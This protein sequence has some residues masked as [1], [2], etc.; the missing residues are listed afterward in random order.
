[1]Y[2]HST[3][4]SLRYPIIY[5]SLFL[6][7]LFHVL[8]AVKWLA[9]ASNVT[10]HRESH[11]EIHA[12]WV[13]VWNFRGTDPKDFLNINKDL[14]GFNWTTSYSTE[15]A[16]EFL[17]NANT[18]TKQFVQQSRGKRVIWKF[19]RPNIPCQWGFLR[20]RVC[21]YCAEPGCCEIEIQASWKRPKDKAVEQ[22]RYRTIEQSST[23]APKS[24]VF[25]ASFGQP[26]G[27]LSKIGAVAE[28]LVI[29]KLPNKEV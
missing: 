10:G 16:K 3:K 18:A 28:P 17:W 22:N 15:Y 7:I 26:I 11:I 29:L 25:R 4:S 27:C 8:V 23:A 5:A 24:P 12:Y 20:F 6:S 1:M 9:L 19:C 21:S 2:I 14:F 13:S